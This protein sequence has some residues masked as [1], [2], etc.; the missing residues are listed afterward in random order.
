[1]HAGQYPTIY[2]VY[3]TNDSYQYL[4]SLY[5]AVLFVGGNEM[6][7]RE[8]YEIIICTCILVFMAMYNATVFGD[9]AVLTEESGK[10]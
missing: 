10:K 4:V 8:D 6:G 7:P 1:V 5:Y 3:T 9:M 2:R